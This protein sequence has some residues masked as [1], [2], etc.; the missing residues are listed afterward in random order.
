[1]VDATGFEPA[2]TETTRSLLG[3]KT[4]LETRA[5]DR[6]VLGASTCI[7]NLTHAFSFHCLACFYTACQRFTK[8]FR[9]WRSLPASAPIRMQYSR[10]PGKNL[11]DQVYRHF[12]QK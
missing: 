7:L 12:P 4:W 9:Q 6:P 2:T 3:Q 1:M 8:H 5:S 11:Q 10:F